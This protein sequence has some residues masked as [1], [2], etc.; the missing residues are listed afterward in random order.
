GTVRLEPRQ[1]AVA[2]SWADQRTRDVLV[3]EVAGC[4]DQDGNLRSVVMHQITFAGNPDPRGDVVVDPVLVGSAARID[5]T[6]QGVAADPVVMNQIVMAAG[7]FR[8]V[9][10]G[11]WLGVGGG[12]Q[13][14]CVYV[15]AGV[16][17]ASKPVVSDGTARAST[18]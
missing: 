7:V 11:R 9:K 17:H 2:R 3:H 13:L 8:G 16:P 4:A 18:A 6:N 1:G 12:T 14:T 5:R 10:G 15:N